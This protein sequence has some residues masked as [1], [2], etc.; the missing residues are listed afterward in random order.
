[1]LVR[2]GHTGLGEGAARE[3]PHLIPRGHR[4]HAPELA[5]PE[6][7]RGVGEGTERGGALHARSDAVIVDGK[8]ALGGA[9]PELEECPVP[10][11][12]AVELR[13]A[14]VVGKPAFHEAGASRTVAL[15]VEYVGEGMRGVR[16]AGME[17]ERAL[18]ETAASRGIARFRACEGVD[19]EEP[20]VVAV[21]G[22]QLLEDTEKQLV[23]VG[24]SAEA[25]ETVHASDEREHEGVARKLME[26]LPRSLERA[27]QIG[28]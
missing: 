13:R 10:R 15:L 5:A 24:A 28:P 9:S 12:V 26:V 1:M 4:S 11:E 20:P 23:A 14:L 3:V 16:V 21:G 22:G 7:G 8:R 19:V 6:K 27:G 2:E 18:H 17:A 25:G